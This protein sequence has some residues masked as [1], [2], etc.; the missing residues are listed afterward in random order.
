MEP[1]TMS[2]GTA[3]NRIPYGR[4]HRR[5]LALTGIAWALAAM[6]VL[7]ISFTLSRMITAWGLTGSQAGA[8]G[9]ASLIGMVLGSVGGGRLADRWGRV[10][11]FQAAVLLYGLAAGL[12]ALA[13]GYHSAFFLRVVTGV[14]IGATAT[15]A[16]TYLS[17]H[18]PTEGRGRYLTYLDTFWAI[19]TI[20]AVVTA[21]VVLSPTG[22][23][24]VD[25]TGVDDWRLLFLFATAP[26]ALVPVIRSLEETPYYL[27]ERGQVEAARRR[28]AEIARKNG[29]SLELT[30]VTLTVTTTGDGSGS[31]FRGILEPTVARRTVVI[32]VAWF[33]GNFG[34][35]GVFIWLPDTVGAAGLVGGI[36]VYL[37]LA[38][39]VQIPGY[40]TA[41]VLVERVGRRATVGGYLALSGVSTGLFAT[42][43]PGVG[44]S[45]ITNVWPFLFG[46]LAV[47][48]FSVGAFGALRAYTPELFP[49][50]IRSTG[51]GL[52]E[53]SGRVA[54]ILGP[55]VAGALVGSGYVVALTPLAIAFVAGGLV[56]LLFGEETNRRRL[57]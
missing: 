44:T 41:A 17:E 15:V 6:E 11:T 49:T 37:L 47:S 2:V 13:V 53:G 16:T 48:F 39:I 31:G 14:G 40:L 55:I 38:A 32:S 33:G 36:Y 57:G 20:L 21:W 43:I 10:T 8:L 26:I 42:T 45:S 51:A 56:V 22:T 3:L 30:D 1:A 24:M 29:T 54:G 18:L 5:V 52:A 19:G 27:V 50:P 23:P 7:L 46:L 35:Y 28:L 12:T 25:A 9:S 4:F 34:F